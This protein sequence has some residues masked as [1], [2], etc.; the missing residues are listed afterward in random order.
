MVYI[1]CNEPLKDEPIILNTYMEAKRVLVSEFFT[2]EWTN[3]KKR[4]LSNI[5]IIT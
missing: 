4:K 1:V 5:F 2:L 3:I